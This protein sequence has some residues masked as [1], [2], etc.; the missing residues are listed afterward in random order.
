MLQVGTGVKLLN[1]LTLIHMDL[2][3]PVYPVWIQNISTLLM[4]D[5]SLTR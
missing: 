5:M 2:I 1:I 4:E 3:G